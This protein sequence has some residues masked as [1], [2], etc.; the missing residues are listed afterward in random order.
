MSRKVDPRILERLH[1]EDAAVEP[2]PLRPEEPPLPPSRAFGAVLDELLSRAAS[3]NAWGDVIA[4]VSLLAAVGWFVVGWFI[5][6]SVE[7]DSEGPLPEA[8]C[9][10]VA[11]GLA[12][13]GFWW[14][15]LLTAGA[16]HLRGVHAMV[17]ETQKQNRLVSKLLDQ[18]EKE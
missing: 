17:S 3:L 2:P 8:V 12:V 13:S 14:R 15:A 18:L 16:A 11:I 9:I 6:H 10:G 1:E 4:V 7:T 5:V